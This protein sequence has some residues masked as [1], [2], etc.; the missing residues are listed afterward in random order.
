[1]ASNV[2][3]FSRPESNALPAFDPGV[4]VFDRTN[5]AHVSAWNTICRL[6]QSQARFEEMER[7]KRKQRAGM[8]VVR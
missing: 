1:M 6:G 4:P 8:E 2:I 7:R 5:P 3:P